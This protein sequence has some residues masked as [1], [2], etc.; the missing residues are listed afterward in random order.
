MLPL[1]IAVAACLL[2]PW[3]PY[4]VYRNV[5]RRLPPPPGAAELQNRPVEE[6]EVLPVVGTA[7]F[8]EDEGPADITRK[9]AR[10]R[11]TPDAPPREERGRAAPD[12]PTPSQA[13][14]P[15][16]ERPRV[17]LGS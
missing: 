13:R 14:K 5:P 10:P 15:A 6:V 8:A 17:N 9:P 11:E 7:A 1:L 12:T 4:L 16:R 2:V 3:L